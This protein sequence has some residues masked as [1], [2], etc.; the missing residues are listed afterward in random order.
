M[1]QNRISTLAFLL[2]RDRLSSQGG[3]TGSWHARNVCGRVT[4]EYRS[5]A[6]HTDVP[7]LLEALGGV[8][9]G[10]ALLEERVAGVGDAVVVDVVA[11]GDDEVDVQLL[12]HQSHLQAHV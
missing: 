11:G 4:C 9:V 7:R 6:L 3:I 12:P 2:R 5:S 8:D 1:S 10:E